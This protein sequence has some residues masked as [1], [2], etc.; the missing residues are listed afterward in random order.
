MP[1]GVHGLDNTADDKLITLTA[2]WGI[3]DMEIVFAIFLAF[4]FEID[5]V[6]EGLETL[7]TAEI[8]NSI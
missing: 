5:S 2:T 8:R 7:G 3:E 1:I 4:K 6:G